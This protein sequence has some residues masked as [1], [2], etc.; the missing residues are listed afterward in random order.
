MEPGNSHILTLYDTWFS[1]TWKNVYWIIVPGD[2]VSVGPVSNKK[3]GI[4]LEMKYVS[5][6]TEPDEW[7]VLID[8]RIE[9]HSSIYI[10]PTNNKIQTDNYNYNFISYSGGKHD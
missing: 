8:G 7:D 2:L 3:L 10:Q 1:D 5:F 4:A 9:R 6:G